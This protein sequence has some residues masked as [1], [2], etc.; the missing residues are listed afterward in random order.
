[1]P[2]GPAGSAARTVPDALMVFDGVCNVCSGYVRAVAAMD[3]DGIIS[4]TS[5][6]SRHGAQLCRQNGINPNDPSTF[7]FI[8]DGVVHEGTDAMIAM[9]DC[10]PAPW[11][12][13]R[14]MAIIP[15][16]LRDAIYR[17]I[18]RNRYSIFG[19]RRVCV[20]PPQHL[21]ARFI[22]EPPAAP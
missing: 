17:W 12:W 1:M 5:I 21:R 18:A 7:L 9:F 3:R 13:L 15:R 2:G 14:T 20:V 11:R 22:D 19:R 10:L 16:G 8:R 4:F 6:Q